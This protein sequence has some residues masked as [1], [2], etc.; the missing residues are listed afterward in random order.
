MNL[1]CHKLKTFPVHL[2]LDML[3]ITTAGTAVTASVIAA[4]TSTTAP[5]K[6]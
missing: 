1:L 4:F 2:V 6:Y 5:W 3:N